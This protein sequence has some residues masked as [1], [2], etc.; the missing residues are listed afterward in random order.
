MLDLQRSLS[1]LEL[2]RLTSEEALLLTELIEQTQ[3]A[4]D[5]AALVTRLDNLAEFSRCAWPLLEPGTPLEWNWHLDL[6]CEWLTLVQRRE[7][8]RLIINVPPQ[9]MKSRLISVFYPAWSWTKAAGHR[10]LC[11][12]YSGDLATDHN[13][14]RRQILDSAWFQETFPGRVAFSRDQ[15]RVTSFKNTVGGRMMVP[16]PTSTATGRGAHDVIA[17]DLV[18]VDD[19]DSETKR[20]AANNFWDRTLRSRLSN[21]ITGAFI[22]VMQRLHEE[23]LTGHLL[24]KNP[25]QW[26][27]IAIP[28]IAEKD[29]TWKFPISGRVVTR[30]QGEPLWPARFPLEICQAL[31]KDFGPYYWSAQ[32]QQ[33]PAPASGGI[34]KR[35]WISYYRERPSKFDFKCQSWDCTFKDTSKS[36]FVA[37][38]V[39]ARRGGDFYL[40]RRVHERMDTPA[41]MAAIRGTR[42]LHRDANVILIEDKANGPAVISMLR[43]EIPGILAW[44]PKGDSKESRLRAVAPLFAAGNVHFPDPEIEGNEW[45]VD[46]V[47]QLVKFPKVAHDDDC[48]AT[49]QALIYMTHEA[50]GYESW[51]Q[52]ELDRRKQTAPAEKKKAEAKPLTVAEKAVLDSSRGN[53]VRCSAEDWPAVREALEKYENECVQENDQVHA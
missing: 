23:D 3:R 19:A 24:K 29:E 8:R 36:D 12:S 17:D 32:Y 49:S 30:K 50:G 34:I 28:M 35:S 14:E 25:G 37:G 46:V 1:G 38:H 39:W 48:D 47:E 7:C 13:I 31:E 20:V 21:Q 22:V 45:V 52:Q 53:L 33:S 27:H 51:L 41:T 26:E 6:I 18:S 42:V 15:N 40:L 4:E 16:S 10:F 5:Q 43:N 44:D 2:D 9:T 11:S